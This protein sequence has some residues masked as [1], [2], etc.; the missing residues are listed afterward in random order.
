MGYSDY[1]IEQIKEFPIFG[2]LCE[3]IFELS[4]SDVQREKLQSVLL[5]GG[6]EG[7]SLN[8]GIC[9][10]DDPFFALKRRISMAY[11]VIRNEDTFD[12]GIIV[13]EIL[14]LNFISRN[15]YARS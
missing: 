12:E 11:L 2:E 8:S 14:Y 15:G 4:S 13:N 7:Y 9:S 6:Y 1:D 10:K 3:M 5:E